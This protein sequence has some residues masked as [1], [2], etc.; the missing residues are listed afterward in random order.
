[1]S[2][3]NEMIPD[4]KMRDE[5]KE[6]FLGTSVLVISWILVTAVHECFHALTAM[7]LG[8]EIALIDI[9]FTFGSLTVQGL[10]NP[11]DTVIVAIAGTVGLTA[12]GV[13]FIYVLR[14]R[15]LNMVG[16]IFLARAWIDS[17]PLYNFDGAHV[18]QNSGLILA[19]MVAI[20]MVLISGGAI[21]HVIK[22]GN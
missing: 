7:A 17:L 20:M 10:M 12:I 15:I 13:V 1:M 22:G 6:V 4:E 14:S 19:W 11:M 8:Y 9:Q 2:V 5:L 18:A 16:V 21:M 3:F